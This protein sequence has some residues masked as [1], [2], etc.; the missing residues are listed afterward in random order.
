MQPG[1][2]PDPF[3]QAEQ[4]WWDGHQ[5]T[6]GT[7]GRSS[8]SRQVGLVAGL[9]ALA[10]AVVGAALAMFT[11]VSLLTGT[12]TVWTGAALTIVAAVGALIV[13]HVRLG[14]KVTCVI[15]AVLAIASGVYD[16]VQL[17]HKRDQLNNILNNP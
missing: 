4:R 11:N 2:Y 7:H 5:W 17:Q 9:G 3:G 13:K 12:G 1:W 6:P 10:L 8:H 16:E 15:L 14:L